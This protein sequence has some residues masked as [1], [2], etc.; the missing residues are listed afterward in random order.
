MGL[1]GN[2]T[3]DFTGVLK[4]GPTAMHYQERT[5]GTADLYSE[6]DQEDG[7]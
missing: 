2:F 1:K 3:F 7:L 5:T 6:Q 4:L